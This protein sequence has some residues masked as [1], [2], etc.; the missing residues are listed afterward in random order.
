MEEKPEGTPNPLNP[1]LEADAPDD[2]RR[3]IDV[4]ESDAE[5]QVEVE[6]PEPPRDDG[7]FVP[8]V[9]MFDEE[10]KVEA[11]EHE[12]KEP[13]AKAEEHEEEESKV[14]EHEV[15]KPETEEPEMKTE[16]HKTEAKEH[17]IETEE[18]G[19]EAEERET[20]VEATEAPKEKGTKI[21]VVE[22]EATEEE[23][24]KET[25]DEQTAE[26]TSE[27]SA[28]Q[29]PQDVE[30]PA[31]K[32]PKAP[33][34][35]S[36]DIPKGPAAES[37]PESDAFESMQTPEKAAVVIDMVKPTRPE[38]VAEEDLIVEEDYTA[39][40][41]TERNAMAAGI[42]A[43]M[44]A[45]MVSS[46]MN[47]DPTNRPME[48]APIIVEE[49]PKRKR[50][51]TGLIIGMVISLFVAVGCG[52]AAAL[53]FMNGE[54]EDPV[55]IAMSRVVDGEAPRNV[56]LDGTISFDVSDQTSPIS[57][58]EL[59]LKSDITMTSLVNETSAVLEIG[60]RGSE[61][62]VAIELDEVYASGGDLY[63][64]I[65]GLSNLATS[66]EVS[67]VSGGVEL[68]EGVELTESTETLTETEVLTDGEML[69]EEVLTEEGLCEDSSTDCVETTTV[70][71]ASLLPILSAL[72]VL[73]GEWIRIPLSEAETLLPADT[74]D[75]SNNVGCL[76]NL[77]SGIRSNSNT[78][79]NI[80][81]KYPFVAN[82]NQKATVA[83]NGNPI[84]LVA[85][86]AGN[87]ADFARE[88]QS[89]TALASWT[90][91]V[92]DKDAE[93]TVEAIVEE[94]QNLPE[95][96]AEVD[97]NYN[98]TRLLFEVDMSG[99]NEML[100]TATVD[101]NFS[102]PTNINVS[103]PTE[104]KDISDVLQGMFSE[105]FVTG[106]DGEDSV[107]VEEQN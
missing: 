98:F 83:S 46:Q 75:E 94:V 73:D 50:K 65:S 10:E 88:M 89:S 37:A 51:K 29:P 96:Y 5:Q 78:V 60:L 27:E 54:K 106:D 74:S 16:E 33:K 70:E 84:Y 55:A 82:S 69:T 103:E 107:V 4:V 25:L 22:V 86:D 30:T 14:E 35:K 23:A 40:P 52:V 42:A 62:N 34:E 2:N 11:E 85:V 93:A 87:F 95:L 1:N 68:A 20:E 76:V 59:E 24:N 97:E 64:K 41:E 28:Y 6:L 77:V 36:F 101:L 71:T 53:I 90:S 57:S 17:E 21:K 18:H 45:G 56:A 100:G 102:Y 39:N 32:T 72:N 7:P 79:A 92:G 43:G 13:E 66:G 61:D 49:P 15:E 91:C 104:Y 8:P 105:T 26:P 9:E 19:M 99:G 63:M 38:E 12:A 80:Y 81:N 58:L 67:T 48:K 47:L 3:Q 44:G 31:P